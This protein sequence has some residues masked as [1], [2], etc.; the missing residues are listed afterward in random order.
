LNARASVVAEAGAPG[1][2]RLTTL[3]SEA[4]MALRATPSAVY[5]VGTAAGPVGGDRVVLDVAVRARA[6]LTVRS[7]AASL[8]F[9]GRDHA[10]ECAEM[11]AYD[12]FLHTRTTDG[13]GGP[14]HGVAPS[15]LEI[16]VSVAA[17]ASLRW[18]PEPVV[19][20]RGCRHQIKATVAVEDGGTLTWRD[21]LL[22]GRHG[23]EGGSVESRMSLDVGGRPVLRHELRAGAE[24]PSWA[25]GAVGAGARAVGSLVVVD[26]VW[27]DAPPAAAT[28][29]GCAVLPL[30]GP[31]ALVTALAEASGPLRSALEW[32]AAHLGL[33]GS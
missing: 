1:T 32:G 15:V 26:P 18:L 11:A 29:A 20:V 2:T 12:A 19:A 5:L 4:P 21:E 17:G 30:V 10:V 16:N 8:A 14:N 24:F 23:E 25:S 28:S 22:I 33:D 27:V 9:P 13:G 3:R 7:I 6:A 31:A